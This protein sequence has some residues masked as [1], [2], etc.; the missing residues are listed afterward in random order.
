MLARAPSGDRVNR[1][2]QLQTLES[3][4]HRGSWDPCVELAR[5]VLITGVEIINGK[6]ARSRNK[7]LKFET[8][9]WLMSNS[10]SYIF[11]FRSICS[12][13]KLDYQAVRRST[14]DGTITKDLFE[15]SGCHFTIGSGVKFSR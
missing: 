8:E 6:S 14:I 7:V 1:Q 11:D 5:A 3:T 2:R 15:K 12:M 10:D 4:R 13:L 9:M